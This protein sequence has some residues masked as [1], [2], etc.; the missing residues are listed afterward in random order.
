MSGWQYVV[1]SM[2]EAIWYS[3]DAERLS[4][5]FKSGKEYDYLDVPVELYQEFLSAP[6]KGKFFNKHVKGQYAYG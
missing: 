5:R 3:E 6:S 4:V 2:I 1:S